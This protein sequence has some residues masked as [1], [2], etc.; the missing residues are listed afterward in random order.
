MPDCMFLE[1]AE[2]VEAA[3][4]CELN[5]YSVVSAI[6]LLQLEPVGL[7]SLKSLLSVFEGELLHEL[8][9]AEHVP[10][11]RG[12]TSHLLMIVLHLLE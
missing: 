2:E 10:R 5:M 3:K 9:A 11:H 7:L 6:L 12:M 4:V 8:I 1:E